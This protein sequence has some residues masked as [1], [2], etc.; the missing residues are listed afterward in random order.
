MR[1]GAA[2][3]AENGAQVVV[4]V[5]KTSAGHGLARDGVARGPA[6]RVLIWP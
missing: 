1:Q 6:G 4:S 3:G 5:R 2:E